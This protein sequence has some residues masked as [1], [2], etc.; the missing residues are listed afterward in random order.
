[1]I[2]DR[3]TLIDLA[4]K[5]DSLSSGWKSGM[6]FVSANDAREQL[7]EDIKAADHLYNT[8]IEMAAHI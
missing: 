2:I 7:A 6:G 8:I 4:N 5:I 3:E 1:M